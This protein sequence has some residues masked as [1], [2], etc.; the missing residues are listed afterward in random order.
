[1]S[2]SNTEQKEREGMNNTDDREVDEKFTEHV[3]VEY[4]VSNPDFFKKNR[5][6]RHS[7]Y[8]SEPQLFSTY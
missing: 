4:I 5:T 8:G 1:V 7:H 2:A 6:A 3:S